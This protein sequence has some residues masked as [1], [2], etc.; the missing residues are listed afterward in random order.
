MNEITLLKNTRPQQDPYTSAFGELLGRYDWTWAV[1]L[2][3]DTACSKEALRHRFMDWKRLLCIQESLQ[4]GFALVICTNPSAHLHSLLVGKNRHHKSLWDVDKMKWVNI[5]VDNCDGMIVTREHK[6]LS[7]A[8]NQIEN[9]AS[10][11][12]Y[13]RYLGSN[14]LANDFSYE[15]SKPRFLKKFQTNPHS[16][17]DSALPQNTA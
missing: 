3:E 7:M 5:W 17:D 12:A 16:S 2:T 9:V 8:A 13:G 11:F 6:P 10:S 4:V 14:Q 15:L 1:S